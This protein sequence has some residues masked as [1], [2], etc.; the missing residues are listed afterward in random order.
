MCGWIFNKMVGSAENDASYC[1][2]YA[3]ILKR[4]S[5]TK[6]YFVWIQKLFKI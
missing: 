1:M 4:I 3:K 6:T 5:F 2:D